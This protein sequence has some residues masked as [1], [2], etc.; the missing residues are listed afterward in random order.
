MDKKLKDA[1][2]YMD[3][4]YYNEEIYKNIHR[5][6][7]EKL[8]ANSRRTKWVP[9]KYG[10]V[11]IVTLGVAML[12]VLS[13]SSIFSPQNHDTDKPVVHSPKEEEY[14]FEQLVS[15]N[16]QYQLIY[17]KLFQEIESELH[18]KEFIFYLEALKRKDTNKLK[19]YIRGLNSDQQM[20]YLISA[21][22]SM[23]YD[24][25]EVINFMSSQAEPSVTITLKYSD[26]YS[27]DL[28]RNIYLHLTSEIEA[29][30][31]EEDYFNR[32]RK[33]TLDEYSLYPSINKAVEEAKN[34]FRLGMSRD[35][36]L[37]TWGHDYFEYPDPGSGDGGAKYFLTFDFL[38][39]ENYKRPEPQHDIT[40]A[41]KNGDIHLQIS[42]GMDANSNAVG[43]H[44]VY[45]DHGEIMM[46]SLTEN[47][48]TINTVY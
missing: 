4:Q 42:F 32:P 10:I 37:E 33:V 24:T 13:N 26:D 41:F 15:E 11:S 7:K 43:M 45:N 22:E 5:G 47:G 19:E 34:S 46:Y 20:E 27:G 8:H 2:D 14:N 29:T 44:M 39:T 17:D 48:E 16:N 6:V 1:K 36:I 23:N 12:L 3:H 40:E 25:F 28:V 18:S 38:T 9:L 35:E 30:I 31:D 21:Y